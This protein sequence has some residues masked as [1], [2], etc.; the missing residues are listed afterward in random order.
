[1]RYA[2]ANTA[3]T[4]LVDR[5]LREDAGV[6][7]DAATRAALFPNA[8]NTSDYERLVNRTWLRLKKGP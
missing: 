1:M 2:N 3:S 7:P 8:V 6:Y 5:T 4:Q